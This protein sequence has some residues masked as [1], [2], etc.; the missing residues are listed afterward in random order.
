M[1]Y[2]PRVKNVRFSAHALLPAVQIAPG[3]GR[4]PPTQKAVL[5][6]F[7]ARVLQAAA[8]LHT[9]ALDEEPPG[10][11]ATS[12]KLRN[13]KELPEDGNADHTKCGGWGGETVVHPQY[14]TSVDE[15][16]PSHISALP[17]NPKPIPE[18]PREDSTSSVP[19]MAPPSAP[20]FP[21]QETLLPSAYFK[22]EEK[23]SQCVVCWNAAAQGVCI[24]CGHLAGCMECLGMIKAKGWGC[25]VCRATIEQVI[26]VYAV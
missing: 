11:P 23:G 19:P 13:R 12:E 15:A 21:S 7:H 25:P 8:Q 17:V 3:T 22:G 5:Q 2:V 6:E 26:R 1:D 20:P 14:S 18:A 4:F 9:H 24:P 16:G 10:P